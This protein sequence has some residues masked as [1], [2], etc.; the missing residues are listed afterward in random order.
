MSSHESSLFDQPDIN[1]V[2]GAVGVPPSH[3]NEDSQEDSE[4]SFSRNAS[5]GSSINI[6]T[7]TAGNPI[8]QEMERMVQ[9]YAAGI[10]TIN[11]NEIWKRGNMC[12]Y[13][14]FS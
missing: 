6:D 3:H 10:P 8:L 9:N 5:H 12:R 1:E 11:P 2:T 14:S 13:A 7:M 4:N